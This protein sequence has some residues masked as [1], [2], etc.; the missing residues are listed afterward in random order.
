MKVKCHI[1]LNPM[2][3]CLFIEEN[4]LSQSQIIAI[5]SNSSGSYTLFYYA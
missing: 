3:I 5:T 2:A 1:E 4:R